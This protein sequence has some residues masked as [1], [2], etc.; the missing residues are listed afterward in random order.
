[1]SPRVQF[2]AAARGD[3]LRNDR[4]QYRRRFLPADNVEA[5]ECFVDE[6]QGVTAIGK[7]AVGGGGQQQRC[8]IARRC[9]AV[10]G[11]QQPPSPVKAG[12]VVMF[13]ICSC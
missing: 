6:I 8:E 5:F 1:M 2:L 7:N 12:W 4:R 9:A 11:C 10:Y 13:L 3:Q